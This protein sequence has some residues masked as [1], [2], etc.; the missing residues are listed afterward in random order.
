MR[1]NMYYKT[2]LNFSRN[3]LTK[4][5]KNLNFPFS[6]TPKTALGAAYMKFPLV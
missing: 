6:L 3:R 4:S 1:K 5:G 2:E